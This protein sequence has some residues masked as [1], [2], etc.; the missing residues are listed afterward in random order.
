M[1]AQATRPFPSLPTA[2]HKIHIIGICGTAMGSLA[3]MLVE[4]GFEVRG[5]DAM[6]YPPMSDWLEAR[7]IAIMMGYAESNLDWNPDLVVVG[8]VSK[9][10]Y[11]D[12]VA[13]RERNI[14]YLSL[15]EA[16]RHF[17]FADKRPLVLTGTHG[18]TTTTSM[19]AWILSSAG[20]DPGFMVGGITGNF[21]SNYRLSESDLFVI[22]GDEY[23]TAYFDKVPKF[24]H[25]A[26]FRATINNIEF[27]H[28][29]IYPDIASI[30]FVFRRF[31]ELLPAEGTLWVNG[32]DAR[33]LEVSARTPATRRTFGL[34]A[35]ND[36]RAINLGYTKTTAFAEFVLDGRSLG[37]FEVPGV[38]EFNVRN[39]LGAAA[40]ALDEG[41]DADTIR[42]ALLGFRH[43]KKRQELIAEVNGVSVYDDF[44]HHP[45]AVRETLAAL[46]VRHPNQRI[47]AIFEAKSNTS[48]RRVFQDA[49]PLAFSQAD[50]VILSR[51]WRQDEDLPL[52][53]RLDIEELADSIRALGAP[54]ELIPEVDNIVHSVV[55]RARPGDVIVGLS[56]SAFGGLHGKIVA[57]LEK[58]TQPET[59]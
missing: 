22:E 10:S 42:Q 41:V 37:V 8:N 54:T 3:A 2:I 31:A 21:N 52:E 27:D 20:R 14:P 12:A 55:A 18:K 33:A 29:D 38:G 35:D 1:T 58:L 16:L 51:P 49:Y 7:G 13:T 59:T 46:R 23:D 53:A 25:Y 11:A 36:F 19:L 28:A 48:R 40:L 6:A 39:M 56:G 26:P 44:A 15:P 30:E 47:W 9:P 32:D 43:T 34:G 50:H 4:R 17:I 57:A 24:W 45:T 5:S